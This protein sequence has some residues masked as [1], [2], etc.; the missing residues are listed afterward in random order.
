[1]MNMQKIMK[2][3]QKMQ[4]RMAQVQEELANKTVEASAGGGVVRV[5]VTGQ[6]EVKEVH[7]DPAV[8]D[9]NDIEMLEDL[10]C[11]P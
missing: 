3:V 11:S 5:V 7:I 6:Q 9:V 1:M 4:A 2:Q 8:V 10:S